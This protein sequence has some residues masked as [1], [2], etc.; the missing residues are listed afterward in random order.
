[1]QTAIVV[2]LIIVGLLVIFGVGYLVYNYLHHHP[3][4]DTI[5]DLHNHLNME[6]IHN[7]H[8]GISHNIG[9]ENY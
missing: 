7:I 4:R 3:M 2:A 8:H 9:G 1:M 5:H 6:H